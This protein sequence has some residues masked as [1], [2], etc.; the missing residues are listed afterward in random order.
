LNAPLIF[1]A[2]H[3]DKLNSSRG[4]SVNALLVELKRL[5]ALETAVD[6]GC[7]LGYFSG[8]LAKLGLQVSAVD[9]R[10]QNVDE[11]QRRHPGVNFRQVDAQDAALRSLGT[12]DLVFCFGLL[13]HL[14]NPLFTIRSLYAMTKA[15]LL[16]ESVIFPGDEP[17]MALI[18]EA[19]L[20]D[21]GLNHIAF[22]PTEACVVKMLYRSGFNYIYG[23]AQQPEH[24]EYHREGIARR[25][26]T[27]LVASSAPLETTQLVPIAEPSSPI[28]PWD[29]LSGTEPP[30]IIEKLKRFVNKPLPAQVATIKRIVKGV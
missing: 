27:M 22:Y 5:L 2:D 21:Q 25:V 13:Y 18:D 4:A 8:L 20:D 3:Y 23:F 15:L 28:R 17:V 26:R 9:G 11:A 14:E 1:D 30:D 19:H 7:G 6:V 29:P 10:Q 24:P 16:V 12:F